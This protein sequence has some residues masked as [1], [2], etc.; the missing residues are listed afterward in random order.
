MEVK[1]ADGAVLGYDAKLSKGVASVMV[2]VDLAAEI[3]KKAAS[4]PDGLEKTIL[5]GA[6]GLLRGLE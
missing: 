5:M 1:S 3:E 2:S 4:L 6:A